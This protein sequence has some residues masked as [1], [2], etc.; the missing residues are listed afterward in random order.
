MQS[1][2]CTQSSDAI[3][4]GDGADERGVGVEG[5]EAGAEDGDDIVDGV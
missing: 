4:G 1:L 2:H 5:V 3:E